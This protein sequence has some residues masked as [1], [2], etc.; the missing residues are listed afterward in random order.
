MSDSYLPDNG[1]RDILLSLE[2][3]AVKKMP[4]APTFRKAADEIT[5]L[6]VELAAVTAERDRMREALKPFAAITLWTDK[7]PDGPLSVDDNKRYV[8]PQW[9]VRARAALESMT[10]KEGE[11]NGDAN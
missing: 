9:I 2:E 1:Q 6:R 11:G 8:D 5:R 4:H 7:Y 3:L 10:K